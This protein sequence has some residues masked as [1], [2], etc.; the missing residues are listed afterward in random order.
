M[1]FSCPISYS[2]CI[3]LVR[4]WKR[5][6]LKKRELREQR[7]LAAMAALNSLSLG[8]QIRQDMGPQIGKDRDVSIIILAYSRMFHFMHVPN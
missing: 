6:S 7:Q 5:R 1:A 4:I 8:P 2:S 3:S